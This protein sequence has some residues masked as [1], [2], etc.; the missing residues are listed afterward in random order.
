MNLFLDGTSTAGGTVVHHY[1]ATSPRGNATRASAAVV[2]VYV[3]ENRRDPN[4]NLLVL[5][6]IGRRETIGVWVPVTRPEHATSSVLWA[7]RPHKS[8]IRKYILVFLQVTFF[9]CSYCTL[10]DIVIVPRSY[11]ITAY[12]ACT[13]SS[14]C[15]S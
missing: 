2:C 14:T 11:R 7:R 10:L 8:V 1:H 12:C 3:D 5:R 9:T 13:V 4:W 15:I 6:T